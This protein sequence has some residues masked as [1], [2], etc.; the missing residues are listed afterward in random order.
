M[1]ELVAVDL[2]HDLGEHL[3]EAAVRVPGEAIV[4]RLLGQS[5][6]RHVVESEVEHGVHHPGHRER[7]TRA[8]RHEQRVVAVAQHLAHLRLELRAGR[9]DLV[10]QAVGDPVAGSHVG[11][12][13]V[14]G[15]GEA[16]RNGQ[17]EPGHLGEVRALAPEQ[18]LL[19]LGAVLEGVDVTH[20]QSLVWRVGVVGWRSAYGARQV[21]RLRVDH[22]RA[23]SLS[24]MPW[25]FGSR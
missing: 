24:W 13:R 7:G 23:A 10:H 17:P 9:R 1:L 18:E 16:G 4:A 3:D 11:L 14:G 15:D 25:P 21:R 22:E 19:L 2:E 6:H 20:E 8:H 12:A 5:T